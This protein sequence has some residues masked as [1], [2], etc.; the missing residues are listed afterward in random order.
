MGEDVTNWIEC[1]DAEN[2]D[3]TTESDSGEE[4]HEVKDY[5]LAWDERD[6]EVGYER[7]Q[8]NQEP[9]SNQEVLNFLGAGTETCPGSPFFIKQ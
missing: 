7:N 6:Q 9:T 5:D 4:W 3:D 8:V 2:D 1:S